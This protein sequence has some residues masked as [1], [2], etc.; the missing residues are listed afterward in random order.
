MAV[1]DHSLDDKIIDSAVAE[2]LEQGYKSASVNRIARNAG[3]TTGALYTRYPNKDALFC[4]LIS[5]AVEELTRRARRAADMYYQVRSREDL[6]MFLLAMEEEMNIYVDVIFR[7][8]DQCVLLFCRSQGSSAWDL[9]Q[10]GMA[11]KARTTVEF[12]ESLSGKKLTG[13]ELLL[14]QQ[15]DTIGRIL[16]SGYDRGQ[17]MEVLQRIYSFSR[18]GWLDLFEKGMD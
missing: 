2:F 17:T 5:Q 15:T 1:K 8:Y 3:V 14:Q 4:S 12:L 18:A 7:Y 11:Y 6:E 9:L 13:V 16:D 10:K